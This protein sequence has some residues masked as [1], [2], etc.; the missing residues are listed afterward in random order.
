MAT[1]EELLADSHRPWAG[2]SGETITGREVADF[3]GEVEALLREEGWLRYRQWDA[4][5]D[6]LVDPGEGA[7]LKQMM[8]ALI[9]FFRSERKRTPGYTLTEA[10]HE[11]LRRS[12]DSDVQY[13]AHRLMK[14]ALSHQVNAPLA[15]EDAWSRR[16]ERTADEVLDLVATTAKLAIVH[17]PAGA[18]AA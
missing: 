17:G 9:D 13:V 7:S 10:R 5:E 2:L 8:R 18:V 16:P 11:V 15:D 12:G 14:L 6:D 4:D 1:I 3:L